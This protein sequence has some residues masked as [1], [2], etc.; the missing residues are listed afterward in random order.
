MTR[1]RA[2][3][4][5]GAVALAALAAGC[6]RGDPNL[7]RIERSTQGP[8]EFAIVPGK[9]LEIPNNLSALP[10]PAPEGAPN[11]TDP[12]PEADAVA[13]LGGNPDR[14]RRDGTAP[15]S[16]LVRS[17]TRFGVDPGVREE[18]AAQDLEFRRR[19]RGRVLERLF[20]I[21]TYYDAYERS[22]LDQHG[23]QERWRRA[24]ARSSGAPPR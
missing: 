2:I 11:R 9:P 7:M 10:P 4:L 14:L 24:G 1:G 16:A 21:T 12:T 22:E 19:N 17:A 20:N 5:A 6:E 18:L 13:A 15:D 8:D 23:E 3:R